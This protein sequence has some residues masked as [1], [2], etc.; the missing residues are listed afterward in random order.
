MCPECGVHPETL[1]RGDRAEL[2]CFPTLTFCLREFRCWLPSLGAGMLPATA[3]DCLGPTGP[4]TLNSYS[5]SSS[6]VLGHVLWR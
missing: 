5:S 6:E 2:S 4:A 1:F 3:S